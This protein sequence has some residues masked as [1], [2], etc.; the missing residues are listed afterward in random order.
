[1]TLEGILRAVLKEMFDGLGCDV[2]TR[3]LGVNA[4]LESI[5]ITLIESM[6]SE[7]LRQLERCVDVVNKVFDAT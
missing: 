1:M 7:D 4:D 5:Q 2:I 3:A 6:S